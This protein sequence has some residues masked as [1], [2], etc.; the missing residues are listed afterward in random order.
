[1]AIEREEPGDPKLRVLVAGFVGNV[2]EWYDFAVYGFFAPTI[3]RLF[4][5]SD[6]PVTSLVAAFGAFAAGFLMRPLGAIIFGHV[7][8]L[9][10]RKRA[11]TLSVAMMAVPT[12]L[13]GLLPTHAQIGFGAAVL[14]VVLRMIQGVSV[15]GEY[16]G[17]FVFLAEH[18][19]RNRRGFFA[20]WSLVGATGGILLGSAVGAVITGLT[21]DA[22]LA[23]WGWR[24]P[25]V[26]G[27]LVGLV[28]LVIRRGIPEQ[29]VSADRQG[30][31]LHEAFTSSRRQLLQAVGLNAMGAVVFYTVFIYI[32]TWLVAEV[33]ETKAQ[34]LDINTISMVVLAVVVVLVAIASDRFGRRPFLLIGAGGIAL[35]AWPLVWL[36]HHHD[37]EM[38]LAG[39]VGFALLLGIFSGVIPVS[40]AELFPRRIRV[41]AASLSYNLPYALFGGTAPIVA[42]WLVSGTGDAMAI[43]WPLIIVSVLAFVVALGMPETRDL[44]YE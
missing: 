9:V 41:S 29:K 15:G 22:Q 3:G 6:D 17:S 23:A 18:A 42:T 44:E 4:F 21:T 8:D 43:T 38:I 26:G 12:C 24:I 16:T 2:L 35:F 5:P 40:V 25:F 10:G 37:F 36:M 11:L 32:A 7:G 39:Q 13:V 20:S 27:V 14:M 33:G 31:P 1:M 34:A 30:S 28:G 19:P